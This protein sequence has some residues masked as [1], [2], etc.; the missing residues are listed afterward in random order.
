MTSPKFPDFDHKIQYL[1][2]MMNDNNADD[3]TDPTDESETS[4]N[5]H[6]NNK[7]AINSQSWF[8]TQ[9]GNQSKAQNAQFLNKMKNSRYSKSPKKN[10]NSSNSNANKKNQL[11]SFVTNDQTPA[12]NYNTESGSD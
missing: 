10:K 9:E 4:Q 3:Y 11:S 7:K 1:P 12:L 8:T 6:F 5:G 2:N